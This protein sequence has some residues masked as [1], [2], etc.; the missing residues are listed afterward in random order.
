[1][2]LHFTVWF[3]ITLLLSSFTL[4]YSQIQITFPVK[5]IVF[6][7]NSGG[8]ASVTVAGNFSQAADKI[9]ARFVARNGQGTTTDWNQIPASSGLFQGTVTVQGGW[10]D[11]EVRSSLAGNVLSTTTLER[12]GVGEVFVISGQSNAQGLATSTDTPDPQ[13]DRINVITN[14]TSN[15][16]NSQDPT[17][18]P[19]FEKMT[20]TGAYAPYGYTSWCWGYL[21]DLLTSTLNVPVLFINA[22][23]SATGAYNWAESAQGLP[24]VY[25]YEAP[26]QM[27]TGMPYGNLRLS[28]QYYVSLTGV[29]SVLWHQGEW[30]ALAGTD[31]YT[32]FNQLKTVIEKTRSDLGG[33][34]VS[35]MIARVSLYP[36]CADDNC[37]NYN[38]YTNQNIIDAQN[39]TVNNVSNC[40]FGPTTDDIQNPRD[41]SNIGHFTGEE[42]HKKHGQAWYDAIMN[43]SFMSSSQPI[44]ATSMTQLTAACS[45]AG[46]YSLAL[47][48]GASQY[49]WLNAAGEL[50]SSQAITGEQGST[51]YGIQKDVTGISQFAPPFLVPANAGI[52]AITASSTSFCPGGNVTLTATGAGAVFAWSN[53]Q[54]GNSITVSQAGNYTVQVKESNGCE[55]LASVP[56]QVNQISPPA[57]P[58]ITA[59]SSVICQGSSVSLSVPSSTNSYSWSN[60][61]TG[62]S[63]SVSSAGSYTVKIK[64]ATTGCESPS[65]AEVKLTVVSLPA[66]PTVTASGSI[67][68]LCPGTQVTLTST[69]GNS[70]KWSNNITTQTN[71]ISQAGSYTAQ[72]TDNNGCL[73]PASTPVV[74]TYVAKPDKPVVTPSGATSFCAGGSV[75][76]TSSQAEKY[77]WQNNAQTK[78]I[79]VATSGSYSLY[80]VDKYG[81]KSD[82]SDAITITVHTLP[83]KPVVRAD[84]PSAICDGD[85]VTLTTSSSAATY[86]WSNGAQTSST[87]I[88][89]AG[90][91]NLTVKDE[92]GCT[93]PTSDD[94]TVTVNALPAAPTITANAATS[95]FCPENP[96]TLSSTSGKTY[97]WSN[98]ASTQT[99]SIGV[100][101][102]F[103]AR[104]TDA[105]G[106]VSPASNQIV[107]SPYPKPATPVVTAASTTSF[108]DGGSVTLS[109]SQADNYIWNTD[110]IKTKDLVATK[111]GNYS[112]YTVSTNGCRSD[113]S[114]TV[115][116][117]VYALP[118]KPVITASNSTSICSGTTIT[119]SSNT[120]AGY[121]YQ[122]TNSATSSSITT[123][124]AGNYSV[125]VT[126]S[127]ACTSPSSDVVTVVVNPLPDKPSIL[128]SGST[129]F[130]ADKSVSLTANTTETSYLWS[131]GETTKT[132]EV[133]K[134]GSYSLKAK[135]SYNCY[136][137][138]SDLVTTNVRDLPATPVITANSTY[139]FCDGGSVVLASNNSTL[140][141]VWSASNET[142]SQ[143]TATQTGSYFVQV[144]DELG[145]T[146][147]A[148]NTIN[149]KAFALPTYPEIIRYGSY[150][151]QAG[152]TG[153]I[154]HWKR[155][156]EPLSTSESII[157][158]GI[159]GNYTVQSELVY[160]L[161][162]GQSLSCYSKDSG[163]L[164]FILD[165]DA[166][167]MSIYPNPSING[168]I[169]IET[170]NPINNVTVR[171]FA[172]T[173]Q[174]VYEE[175]LPTLEDT[176][177]ISFKTNPGMYI[178]TVDA[179][180][181]HLTR[182][183][184]VQNQQ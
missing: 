90:K 40:F 33:K 89:A 12:V 6:Q 100:A 63:I 119:L 17:S 171:L 134:A 84:G 95:N 32:Y 57:A 99:I 104:I 123:G 180:G 136:S 58:T 170:L 173:G 27:P 78:D 146:S 68:D 13:D 140:K 175:T 112:L 31:T 42:N 169:T 83:A 23:Y 18:F 126:D 11:V 160:T 64:D 25:P 94:V 103:T 163:T 164:D 28:L 74:V 38:T 35:W 109:S 62:T 157:K 143:I 16:S 20:K 121:S 44:A 165:A 162:T 97:I 172:L 101:G 116:V 154:F 15:S 135:N 65:S 3:S 124:T 183:L 86:I 82:A 166:L 179:S 182:R 43:S 1:M 93:S 71:A 37:T 34:N 69:S 77:Y 26:K 76:L 181:I 5:R 19:V 107:V 142:T 110:N 87:M 151:L 79:T 21:G 184:F 133:K 108:C 22:A 177:I 113:A 144:V 168:K 49:T 88:S 53:G 102:T 14:L 39:M 129:T 52:P 72:V 54:T 149:V 92:Y 106:C 8:N 139:E 47:P 91:Y 73:S 7:R 70:Y 50:A 67:T 41:Q 161:S 132:I 60:G 125:K 141:N 85:A 81:C 174:Q 148:S 98:G 24:T 114:N 115:T 96:I 138:S 155:D 145:C 75:T 137:A 30:D 61:Q 159:S 2:K 111:S 158:A 156:N 51:Y 105:N 117:T 66:A 118:A 131:T 127:H 147:A 55:S 36:V 80:I 153:S 176:R 150:K 10:Y 45:S 120:V 152:G 59:S 128:V 130:C 9:E 29:R 48:S 122:W 167:N 56:V 46:K 4:T 178:M